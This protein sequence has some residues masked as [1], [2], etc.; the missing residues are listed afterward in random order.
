MDVHKSIIIS[1][2][3]L[4]YLIYNIHDTTFQ[5]GDECLVAP[6]SLFQTELF[7]VTGPK[8]THIQKR[9]TGDPEDPHDENYLRETSVRKIDPIIYKIANVNSSLNFSYSYCSFHT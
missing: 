5:V 9:S 8:Q 3:T 7:G 4:Y 2:F 6:L 1:F